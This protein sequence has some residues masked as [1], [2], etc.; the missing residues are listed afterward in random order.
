MTT[1]NPNAILEALDRA[2]DVR[3]PLDGLIERVAA[4]P[5][6]AFR[7]EVLE[8]LAALKQNDRARFETL[9][10]R[11]REAGCRRITALDQEIAKKSGDSGGRGPTQADILVQLAQAAELFHAPDR[12]G[13]ADLEI[14]GHRETWR[15]ASKGFR[16]WLTHR[17]FEETQGAPSSE[18]LQSALN[19]IEAKADFD[20]PEYT[21]HLRVGGLDGRIYLD[22]CNKPWQAV[23]IDPQGWRVIDKSPV[24]FRRSA[25]M[26]PLPI[27]VHGG[28]IKELEPFLN[29]KSHD[30]VMAVAYL[31]AALRP[32]GPYPVIGLSGEQGS[33]KSTFC[34]I[35]KA[36][37]DPNTAPLR[38]LPREDRDL[39]IAANNGHVLALDNVS[40][41]PA[42]LSD[43]LCRLSTGGGFATRELHTDQDEVLF[44]VVKPVV[45]NGIEEI[46][47][48]PDLAD[49]S[50]LLTLEPIP[51]ERRR[52]E[53]EFWDKFEIARP[54]I[55]GALLDA[56]ACGLAML[57]Q[58]RLEKLPRMAD[59]ALW[60]TACETAFWPAGT[61]L[62]AYGGNLDNAVQDVLESDLVAVALRTFMANKSKWAGTATELL[63]AIGSDISESQKRSREWPASAR[64][65]SGR[66]R[67]A[68]TLRRKVGVG[69]DFKREGNARARTIHVSAAL[70]NGGTQPSAPSPRSASAV[71]PNGDNGVVQPPTL[72]VANNADDRADHRCA[73]S[74]STVRANP[75]KSNEMA[76]ADG[77]DGISL[78]N[79]NPK[80]PMVLPGEG[81]CESA[82][83][84]EGG[85]GRWH[86]R[87][88]GR[89]GS[90]PPGIGATTTSRTRCVVA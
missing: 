15:L 72:T 88:G 52:T 75:L 46:I 5:G 34:A 47:T 48:R 77:T 27:P 64:A 14:D 78:N 24:R 71:K 74:A 21:V 25:G 7:P 63:R 6:A 65:L 41:L 42:W 44:D 38:A 61:F 36:L 73:D 45:L 76:A 13:F 9:R 82:R 31:L 70:E 86:R 30:F 39:F 18:A 49:R 20:A 33:A 89:R 40:G 58:T 12:T 62:A 68:A 16:R 8:A 50:I 56:V 26:K 84:T 2:A 83:S 32:R 10:A 1:D 19:L 79:R 37:L 28:S 23:E 43:T 90:A 59:F 60:L 29:V 81:D 67:R 35:L 11:L 4:D 87:Y 85:F 53:Q 55:L 54:R 80:K 57:P 69:I 3:E 51:E 17:F 66:L 22:L